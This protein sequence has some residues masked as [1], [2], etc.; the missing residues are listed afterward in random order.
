MR[1]PIF[2]VDLIPELKNLPEDQGSKLAWK[3]YRK[4]FLAWEW[5]LGYVG[6][7]GC[8]CIWE[9]SVGYFSSIL[10]GEWVSVFKILSLLVFA[11][12]GALIHNLLV[13]H[14]INRAIRRGKADDFRP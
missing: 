14:A 1:W 7:A 12:L 8:L 3:Y 10:K 4:S 5:W 2:F 13:I 6:L 11:T 9:K